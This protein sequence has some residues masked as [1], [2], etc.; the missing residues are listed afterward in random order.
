ME[1]EDERRWMGMATTLTRWKE[2]AFLPFDWTALLPPFLPDIKVEQ[3]VDGDRFVV[4]AELPGFDPGKQIDITVLNGLLKIH[5][6]RVEQIPER[7]HTEFRYGG[8]GRTIAL[9]TGTAEDSAV[10]TYRDG[11]LEITFSIGPAAEPGRH[12]TIDVPKVVKPK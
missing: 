12:I 2:S 10:A 4:R 6:E 9:P 3:F 11:I 7:A 8:F 1:Y 5:A